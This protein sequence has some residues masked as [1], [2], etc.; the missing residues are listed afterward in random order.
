MGASDGLLIRPEWM[1]QVRS[2]CQQFGCQTLQADRYEFEAAVDELQQ[3]VPAPASLQ[4]ADALKDLLK[5]CAIAGGTTFHQAY[6][7]DRS[8]MRCINS[9]VEAALHVWSR[10]DE[11]PR[12]TWKR[13]GK[14]FLSAF[15]A[16]HPSSPGDRGAAILR[17]R[18]RN[19]PSL[20][21]LATLAGAS[22]TALCADF[23]RRSRMPPGE[24]LMRVRLRWFVEAV[25]EPGA[26][27]GQLA[28]QAGYSSY[29]NLL[30][31]LRGRTGLIPSDVRRLTDN[32]TRELLDKMRMPS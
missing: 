12:V 11:D 7:R 32:D 20:S 23:R 14:T 5:M 24:Y 28:E 29:Q 10:H 21:E 31:A 8:D 3:T 22:K 18:F 4:E 26:N 15:E 1:F 27:A 17:A 9:P 25:R 30:A 6:H 2:T 13:W 19:P 16:T